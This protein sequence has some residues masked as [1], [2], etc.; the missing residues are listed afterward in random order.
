MP[1]REDLLDDVEDP[2]VG[3]RFDQQHE[4][5]VAAGGAEQLEA[6][7]DLAGAPQRRESGSEPRAPT[8][9][10]LLVQTRRL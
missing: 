6:S 9:C 1:V 10:L 7:E 2:T 3:S 4:L 8:R 5:A